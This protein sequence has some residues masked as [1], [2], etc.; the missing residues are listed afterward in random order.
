MDTY[1]H[2]CRELPLFLDTGSLDTTVRKVFLLLGRM[3]LLPTVEVPPRTYD[4]LSMDPIVW[5][6]RS[7]L[8][9]SL[10]KATPDWYGLNR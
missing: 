2:Q 6:S 8:L 4:L 10:L 1:T 5:L 3:S 7:G 9:N